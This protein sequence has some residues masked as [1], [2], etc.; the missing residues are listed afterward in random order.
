MS[1]LHRERTMS[2][3][4]EYSKRLEK[5]T[6]QS[7]AHLAESQERAPKDQGWSPA[8]TANQVQPHGSYLHRR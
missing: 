5:V 1:E 2:I 4:Q 3:T 6:L 7:G 8:P